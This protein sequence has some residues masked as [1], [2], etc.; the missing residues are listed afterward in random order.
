MLSQAHPS[1][2][3]AGILFEGFPIPPRITPPTT[4]GHDIQVQEAILTQLN[5]GRFWLIFGEGKKMAGK[6]SSDHG[7]TW[8]E[9]ALARSF[10]GSPIE[11]NRQ[12][13]HLSLLHLKSGHL[14]I[15]YGGPAARPGR[16][17]TLLFRKSL[18]DGRTWS[19]VV[20][21]DPIFALC[22]TQG[23]RVLS[24]GRILVPA[25]HWL[26]PD[27]GPTSEAVA[28]SLFYSFV[29]LNVA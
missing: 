19:A 12:E 22:R 28:H 15:V 6:L 20:T 29:Y 21:I 27:A 10:D 23:A 5:D 25:V 1:A 4:F 13:P 7:R 14:G 2:S 18:D 8:G 16:D 17:G 11:Q 3:G 9:T 24:T 26:S